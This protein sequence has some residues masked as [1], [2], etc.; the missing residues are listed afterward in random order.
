MEKRANLSSEHIQGK[1][2]ETADYSLL[3][4]QAEVIQSPHGG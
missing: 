3:D 2:I 1:S 4:I